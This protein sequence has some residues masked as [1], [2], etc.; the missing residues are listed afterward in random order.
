MAALIATSRFFEIERMLLLKG[1]GFI[2]CGLGVI[3]AGTAFE[4]RVRAGRSEVGH[5]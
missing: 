4:R 5:A 2:L 3:A 1:A